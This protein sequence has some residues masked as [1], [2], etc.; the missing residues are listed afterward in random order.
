M[1]FF[2][3]LVAKW[4]AF[5]GWVANTVE[6][7]LNK[8]AGW[9]Y[10][11]AAR[12]SDE[13]IRQLVL[14]ITGAVVKLIRNSFYEVARQRVARQVNLSDAEKWRMLVTEVSSAPAEETYSMAQD[15]RNLLTNQLDGSVFFAPLG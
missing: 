12:L 13:R 7:F 4:K 3:W 14:V 6:R 15:E 8:L 2:E 10:N 9:L 5:T 11:L 1:D